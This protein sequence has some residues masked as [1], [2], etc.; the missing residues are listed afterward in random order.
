ME[1]ETF[2]SSALIFLI[3]ASAMV[4]LFRHLGLG[5]I[6]GLLVAG[7]IVGPHTPGPY[8]TTHVE[9]IRSF[10]ELGVV[11]LLFVIGLEI[12]PARLWALRR[13]VFGLGSLQI[14]L[15]TGAITACALL[16]GFYWKPS[17]VIG[18]TMAVSSTALVMQL[19]QER[20]EVASPHGSSAFSVLLMQDLAIVPMLA[21]IPVL[22][23]P[24]TFRLN[25]PGWRQLAIVA[26]LLALVWA[27]GKYAVPFG[28][29]R[30]ARHR[31]R[32]AF[33]MVSMLSVLLSAWAMHQ[34]GLSFALGAFIMGMLLSGSRYSVQIEAYIEPYR[35]LLTSL[36][37]VAVGMSID[38]GAIAARPLVFVEFAFMVILLKIAIM[39]GLCLAFGVPRA[40]GTR[41][42]FLLGQGGEFGFVLLT[43][44]S[45]LKV[46]DSA[47]FV[48]GVG[49]V[50]V[51]ML[52]TPLIA[53]VG[54][55][56]ARRLEPTGK[57]AEEVPFIEES[58]RKKGRVILAGYGRV[59]HVVAVILHD[60]NVPFIVFDNDPARVARGKEDGFP[61]Y[62][63]DISNPELLAA[64]RVENAA[65]VVLSIDQEQTAL[66]AISH[67][68]NNY[69]SVRVLA[70]ARDL[71]A[72][73]R[74]CQAGA[75]Q[76]LPEALESSL[77]LAADTL[78]MVGV[79]GQDVDLLL[80]GVRRTD[81]QLVCPKE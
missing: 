8:I 38:P 64:A 2:V 30:L 67:I 34:A 16:V 52:L 51:S 76:A 46:I 25:V 27:F 49:V 10:A 61:V 68:R 26:G 23:G 28:L 66:Q 71:E 50:S 60:S 48:M 78:R 80:S 59:G 55:Y 73:G 47:T 39:F 62:Y 54:Y 36:F 22:A 70:R 37:F 3:V 21:L 11:L 58:D 18:L 57:R 13:S 79:P 5:S 74:L 43:S 31:N 19:L 75:T 56:L 41:V 45:A 69:P 35:G 44:A 77:R 65:L 4:V 72:S 29:E 32:E 33:V 42:S 1:L 81:Y 20:G 7:I 15:T 24:E 17:L 53:K 63:G 9:G 12:R 40:V 6:A 14:V